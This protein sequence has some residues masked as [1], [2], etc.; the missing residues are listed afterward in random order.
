MARPTPSPHRLTGRLLAVAAGTLIV[1]GCSSSRPTST[2]TTLAPAT[3]APPDTA[4]T[5][6]ASTGVIT[7]SSPAASSDGAATALT[8]AWSSGDRARASQ[9]AT[10][11]A[12]ATLFAL[13][14][15]RGNLQFRSC[16]AGSPSDCTYRNTA[17][18]SGELYDLAVVQVAKGWYVMSV[19]DET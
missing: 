3:L 1:A 2:S 16:S 5:T 7:P 19:H 11:G 6:T 15:P 9:V 12:I 14:Y 13:P 17:S 4:A 10:P 8:S 18:S